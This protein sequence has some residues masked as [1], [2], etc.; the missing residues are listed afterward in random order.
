MYRFLSRRRPR[1]LRNSLLDG[2]NYLTHSDA[3]NVDELG[4]YEI[5]V[6]IS[7]DGIGTLN[8]DT[9]TR[10]RREFAIKL[11]PAADQ[12]ESFPAPAAAGES[13]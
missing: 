2:I 11:N 8:A 12:R 6:P 4:P 10:L 7:A 1:L 3:A 5:L 9:E 13:L